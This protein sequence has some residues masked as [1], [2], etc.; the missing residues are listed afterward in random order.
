[1]ICIYSIYSMFHISLWS[2]LR[3]I[4]L[5]YIMIYYNILYCALLYYTIIL[6]EMMISVVDD[7]VTWHTQTKKILLKIFFPKRKFLLPYPSWKIFFQT[8]KIF[9]PAWNNQFFNQR[10]NVLYLPEKSDQRKNSYNYW[11]KQYSK[12]KII[13]FV[14][15]TNF[16]YILKKV[17]ELH[18]RCVLNMALP[19]FVSTKVNKLAAKRKLSVLLTWNSWLN[20]YLISFRLGLPYADFRINNVLSFAATFLYSKRL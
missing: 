14:W 16:L 1:M 3:C 17:K 13:I 10:K 6:F 4:T 9:K 20:H 8:K 11:K 12:G 2:I 19:S 15:K 5:Y 7:A 18:F